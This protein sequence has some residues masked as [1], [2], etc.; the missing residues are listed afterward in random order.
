MS[1]SE[2]DQPPCSRRHRAKRLREGH[3]E[4]RGWVLRNHGYYPPERRVW[5]EAY[6]PDT[7]DADFHAHTKWELMALIDEDFNEN[8]THC[9]QRPAQGMD[10]TISDSR[11]HE[12][13]NLP[14]TGRKD[15]V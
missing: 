9:G 2:L 11:K 3:Y 7:G 8:V 5:W 15:E 13:N 4:Y 6:D 12:T 10:E 1:D 14:N